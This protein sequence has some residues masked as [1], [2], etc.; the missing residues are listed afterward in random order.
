MFGIYP[1]SYQEI[2]VIFEDC[3]SIDEVV[4]YGSRAKGNYREGSDIDITLKGDVTKE[5]LNKLWHKLDDSFIPYKF[6][7][8]IYKDLKSQSLIE[9]IERVGKTF[10]K[11]E[12]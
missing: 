1:K 7:I 10:Y 5:D 9:H 3:L 6:D 2:L 12:N 4:I 11:R 8:S